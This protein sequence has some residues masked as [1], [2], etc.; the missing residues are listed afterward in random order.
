MDWEDKKGKEK[1]GKRKK[2]DEEY[3]EKKVREK[4]GKGSEV[5][6]ERKWKRRK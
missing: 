4:W 6:E 2:C 1:E 5:V 3:G